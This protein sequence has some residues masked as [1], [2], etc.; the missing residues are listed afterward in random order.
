M[1]NNNGWDGRETET[2]NINRDEQKTASK[3]LR[4]EYLLCKNEQ[5]KFHLKSVLLWAECNPL[6]T[7][8]ALFR[9]LVLSGLLDIWAFHSI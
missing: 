7:F 6:E 2:E 3:H 8:K 5:K 4:T 1:V 9:R